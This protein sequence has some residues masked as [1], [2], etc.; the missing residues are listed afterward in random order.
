MTATTSCAPRREVRVAIVGSGL[1]GL[2]ATYLLSSY[3]PDS[4]DAPRISVEIFERASTVGM[5]SASITVPLPLAP[6]ASTTTNTTSSPS[7]TTTTHDDGGLRSRSQ[8]RPK[9]EV[10]ATPTPASC[11]KAE[12]KSPQSFLRID[13]PMRVF[14]G[15]YYPQLLALYRHLGIKTKKT[16]FTYSFAT[17]APP[18]TPTVAGPP[19]ASLSATE[20]E[21]L[22]WN[23]R[24]AEK[25]A[26]TPS[27]NIIYNGANGL[28]GVS[29]PSW[30]RNPNLPSPMTMTA[31][32]THLSR[33][34]CYF[35]S[36]LALIFGYL[37][38]LLIALWHHSLGHTSDPTHPLRS[39]TLFQLV[40]DP[41]PPR[42]TP[43][44]FSLGH[45]SERI[46]ESVLRKFLHLNTTFAQQTL[47]PLFSAVM[48]STLGSVWQCPAT[49][50]LDYVA[51]T[52]GKDHFVV[53]DGVGQVV[54]ALLTHL[55]PSPDG[56][57]GAGAVWTNA[58][59]RDV[60][61][62]D[63]KAYLSVVHHCSSSSAAVEMSREVST[64]STSTDRTFVQEEI[65]RQHGP[66]DH[67]IFATQA[68]QTAL[69]LR[70]YNDSLAQENAEK[71]RLREVVQVLEL[72]K[73]EKSTVVNHFDRELLPREKADWRDLNLVTP[74]DGQGSEWVDDNSAITLSDDA[75][76][77]DGTLDSAWLFCTSTEPWQDKKIYTSATHILTTP[78]PSP[79]GRVLMQTTN[80]HPSLSPSPSLTLS[81]STFERAIIDV[82]S[83]LGRQKLF[84]LSRTQQ[85]V[86][87]AGGRKLIL[88]PLQKGERGKV[89]LWVCGS[90]AVGIPLLEGCV[91]SARLVADEIA[92]LE[93]ITLPAH[94]RW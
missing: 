64:S 60:Y 43:T 77:S 22:G 20:Q 41:F 83:H 72:W 78:F 45:T 12:S 56:I 26:V 49:E 7:H 68:N 27:P 81:R 9:L 65:G 5:D 36:L 35:A 31:I 50:V 42:P 44:R 57:E 33:M 54:A 70:Q 76:C 73:Y 15:G 92:R 21:K 34:R 67:M 25:A 89:G 38:L 19:S 52:L 90:F 94:A 84:R 28:G 93:E 48:T 29:L 62:R 18:S 88:G 80:A 23:G 30:L 69:F 17:L 58:A 51:L 13:V 46:V 3:K 86:E 6:S 39:Y 14:T 8:K 11:E 71:Q 85:G 53:K 16:N 24:I 37:Q 59:V 47:T 32:L 63:G 75:S 91:V 40:A 1:T 4:P 61:D 82:A 79:T 66:Y 10:D 2:V 55:G 87:T 74:A